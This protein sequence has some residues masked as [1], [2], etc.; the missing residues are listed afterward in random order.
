V[1]DS[2][3]SL[4]AFTQARIAIGSAGSAVRTQSH[5]EFQ[6]AHAEAR[7]AVW[8]DWDFEK[9]LIG[10]QK[11]SA[12]AIHLE[13]QA[14]TRSLYLQRPDLGRRLMAQSLATLME[15]G[16]SGFDLALIVSNGLS[17]TS[18]E[19]HALPFLNVLMPSLKKCGISV[20]PILTVPNGRV[21][22]SDEIGMALKTRASLILI[23]E[24]PGLSAAD[25]LGAYITLA[26]ARDNTDAQ[27]NCLS[28]IR[29]P[30]G[31]AYRTAADK[32]CYLLL[33]GLRLGVG[34]VALKD[35]SPDDPT[36]LE[37][38]LDLLTHQPP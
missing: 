38:S 34:G 23:G 6:L 37:Q 30:D 2:W 31:L 7:D 16:P 12:Y 3:H 14:E 21:A 4:R 5:L 19:R 8:K 27:R 26:P 32:I 9:F 24:R 22:L 17:T 28:N 20:T 33:K 13:T 25:S 18:V 36:L 1:K 11:Q 35:D 10:V 15:T 29:E